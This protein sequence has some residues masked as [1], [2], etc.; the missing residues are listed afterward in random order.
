MS[1]LTDKIN[2]SLQGTTPE[3]PPVAIEQEMDGAWSVVGDS[4]TVADARLTIAAPGLLRA[5]ADRIEI[6][7]TAMRDAVREIRDE[8]RPMP[9]IAPGMRPRGC[10]LCWPSDSSWPCVTELVAD[11]LTNTLDN[12]GNQE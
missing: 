4:L 2:E 5:A 12:E 8:H 11:D 6:L 9:G 10:L 3:C 7:E 1:D